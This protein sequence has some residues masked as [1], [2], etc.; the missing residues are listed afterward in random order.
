MPKKVKVLD[1]LK[2]NV[3]AK[4]TLQPGNTWEKTEA[5]LNPFANS[6][7]NLEESDNEKLSLPITKLHVKLGHSEANKESIYGPK[8]KSICSPSFHL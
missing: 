2:Q 5:I 8:T 6:L 3:Y 4:I 7:L 1:L